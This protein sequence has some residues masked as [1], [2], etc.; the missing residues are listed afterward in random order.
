MNEPLK[1]LKATMKTTTM[2]TTSTATT[3]EEVCLR[4]DSIVVEFFSKLS[5]LDAK[6]AALEAVMA[7]GNVSIINDLYNI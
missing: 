6:K 7:E 1:G 5:E 3:R 2:K 4:L